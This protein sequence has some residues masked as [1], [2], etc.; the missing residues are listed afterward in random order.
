MLLFAATAMNAQGIV[1]GD[2]DGDGEVT[3]TDVTSAV[4]VILGKAPKQTISQ[5]GDPYSVDNTLVVGTWKSSGGTSFTLNEDGTTSYFGA[6]TYKFRPYQGTLTLYNASQ[7]PFKAINV[8]DLTSSYLTIVENGTF[9]KYTKSDGHD[10]V[11]LGLPSGTLWATCNVG[12]SSPEDYGYYFAWGETEPYDE[13]GGK[14][15]FNWS[16]YKWCNGN[17]DKLTKYCT[18]SSYGNNGFTDGKTEL[19]VDDDAAYVKWGPAWRM[20]S[21]EQFDEL[22]NSNYTTTE[23][24]TQNG[25]NGRLITSKSN[26]NS[27]FLPAAGFHGSSSLSGAGSNGYNWS[28]SLSG[29]GYACYLYFGSSLINSY[30]NDRYYGFSVRP[31]RLSE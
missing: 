21:Q 9:T 4:D 15:T 26:G 16:T 6:A 7:E 1:K 24:T 30:I 28:R 20:P 17:Y 31:V 14:T 3:I 29:R 18:N 2:M 11:D 5:G 27:I 8:N 25:V 10:Y 12:A 19:D 23:W 22:I 13:N